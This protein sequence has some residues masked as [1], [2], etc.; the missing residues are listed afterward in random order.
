MFTLA[1]RERFPGGVCYVLSG[2]SGV[3][4]GKQAIGQVVD[5]LSG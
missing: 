2:G 5:I 1:T 4:V 3:E